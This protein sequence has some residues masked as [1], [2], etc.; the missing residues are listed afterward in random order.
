MKPRAQIR[1]NDAEVVFQLLDSHDQDL[2]LDHLIEIRKQ[3]ALQKL[4][5]LSVTLRRGP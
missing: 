5:D 3:S 4:R 2:S 1:A